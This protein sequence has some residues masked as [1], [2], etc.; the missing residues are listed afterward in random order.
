MPRSTQRGPT[1]GSSG[2][3]PTGTIQELHPTSDIRFVIRE[4]GE[5]SAKVERLITDIGDQM[6]RLGTIE[7]AIDRF[8]TTAIVTGILLGIF[9]PIT[10]GV[11]LVGCWGAH[12]NTLVANDCFTDEWG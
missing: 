1:S 11:F 2:D 12:Y 4:V 5:L 9:L 7:R 6:K 10:A 8:K 3:I